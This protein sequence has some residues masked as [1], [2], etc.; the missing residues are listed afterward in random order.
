MKI[1]SAYT[2]T[3]VLSTAAIGASLANAA[4]TAHEMDAHPQLVQQPTRA[5][6]GGKGGSMVEGA[7]VGFE[8]GKAIAPIMGGLFKKKKCHQ[9]AC[10]IA[11]PNE[12][13]G[14]TAADQAQEQLT[15]GRDG[16]SVESVSEQGMWVRYWRTEFWPPDRSDIATGT[17]ADGSKFV[18]TNCMGDHKVHC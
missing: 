11:A 3:L 14:R 8:I 18:V 12:A 17:C 4:D 1:L 2:T 10:W 5:L 15:K 13:C 7:Q 16:Y 9:L 6:R